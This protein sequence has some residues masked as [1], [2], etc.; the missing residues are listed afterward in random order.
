MG[1]VRSQAGGR[2]LEQGAQLSPNPPTTYTLVDI[3]R[4]RDTRRD[5][6]RGASKPEKMEDHPLN[7]GDDDRLSS[8][9]NNLPLISFGPGDIRTWKK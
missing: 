3:D 9:T 1:Q 6:N 7:V 8:S 5:R 2:R 4:A